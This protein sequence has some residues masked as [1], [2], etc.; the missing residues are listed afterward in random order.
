MK[1][2]KKNFEKTHLVTSFDLNKHE[3]I[4]VP[5]FSCRNT[6]VSDYKVLSD[7]SECDISEQMHHVTIGS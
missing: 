2:E 6:P 1:I 3:T 4:Y 7:P 5:K